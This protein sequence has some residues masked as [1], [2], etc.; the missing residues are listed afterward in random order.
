LVFFRFVPPKNLEKT[1]KKGR[2]SAKRKRV[3]EYFYS[4]WT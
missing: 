3:R 4:M 2:N 1:S